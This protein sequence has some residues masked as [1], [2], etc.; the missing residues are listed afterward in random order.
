M[1]DSSRRGPGCRG[2]RGR[3]VSV[4]PAVAYTPCA[5]GATCGS[6]TSPQCQVTRKFLALCQSSALFRA[7]ATRCA[8]GVGEDGRMSERIVVSRPGGELIGER[9]AGPGP[10]VVLL[11]EGVTDRRGWA[12]VAR[13]LSGTATVV[14]YDRRAFGESAPG[15]E[16]FTHVDD[17]LAVL[18][19][20]ADGKVWLVGAAAGGGEA[21]GGGA[22]AVRA[23]G[24]RRTG[25]GV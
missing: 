6:F 11:H 19:E 2:I 5:G 10:V 17:L 25:T 23:G 18:D 1:R 21:L 22:G 13:L 24:Q 7:S 3:R 15:T 16:A 4:P 9:W 8:G 12:E 14:A 20:V